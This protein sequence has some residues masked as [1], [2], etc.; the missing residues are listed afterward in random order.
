[1]KWQRLTYFSHAG[2]QQRYID[3]ILLKVNGDR[4]QFQQIFGHV[5]RS[6]KQYMS[7]TDETQGHILYHEPDEEETE[8]SLYGI[9]N[10]EYYVDC[11]G[12]WYIWDWDLEAAYYI[13]V[14]DEEDQ[15]FQVTN[16]EYWDEAECEEVQPPT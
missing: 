2:L 8:R 12:A 11:A 4:S 5:S 9:S 6:G 3:D 14:A 7:H 13:D 1:M 10:I 16:W 15:A